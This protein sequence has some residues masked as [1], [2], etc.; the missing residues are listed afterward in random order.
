MSI[1]ILDVKNL[2]K[3]FG[4]FMAVNS[5][6]FAVG[7]GEVFGLVGPN[8]AGKTTT[9]KML[10]TLLPPS[11]GMATVAGFDIVHQAP[12]VRRVIGYVPQ[13]LS[14]DGSLS[15]YENLL[16]FS[17]LY[18][19]PAKE[20]KTLINDSLHFMG[21]SDSAD[22]LVRSYSG[23]M[24]RR[25]EIAQAVLHKPHVLYLDEPTVGLDP[26]ARDAVWKYVGALAKS[27]TTIVMTT[28]YMEE[29]DAMCDII[30]I[31]NHGKIAAMGSPAELKA[32]IPQDG[33]T[34]DLNKVFE[35]YA[36]NTLESE[37][38]GR[39][40]KDVSRTRRTVRRLG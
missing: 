34:P 3:V 25:L 32:S 23:G 19:I 40:F 5:I 14:A 4:D 2:T 10:T 13:L 37:E 24:I 31:M 20:R 27:G 8:G 26:V 35:Y 22:K 6:S 11:S 18:D 12:R 39:E 28:H 29:A 38:S 7:S 15:G 36:G 30:A 21:L 33:G 17:K 16:I 1:T 9:V